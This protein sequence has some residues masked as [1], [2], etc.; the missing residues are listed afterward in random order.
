MAHIRRISDFGTVF[1]EPENYDNLLANFFDS[2]KINVLDDFYKREESK[3]KNTID[4]LNFRIYLETQR[5]LEN[6]KDINICKDQILI[7]LFKEISIFIEEIER[8]NKILKEKQ[9]NQAAIKDRVDFQNKLRE[10]K[11]DFKLLECKY[12]TLSDSHIKMVAENEDLKNQNEFYCEQLKS[13]IESKSEKISQNDWNTKD[14]IKKSF[15]ANHNGYEINLLTGAT[16]DTNENI[17]EIENPSLTNIKNRNSKYSDDNRN[18]NICINSN[19]HSENIFNK[20]CVEVNNINI[21]LNLH[22]KNNNKTNICLNNQS[23]H[24]DNKKKEVGKSSVGVGQ[25]KPTYKT[26]VKSQFS[27]FLNN[28]KN[29]DPVIKHE[30]KGQYKNV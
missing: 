6:K 27:T 22:L 12:N 14:S 8:L 25:T 19:D 4:F 20:E 23:I 11:K 10:L 16:K 2:I 15:I 1:C 3:F 17:I 9:E 28:I 29:N 26:G 5:C 24:K 7:I 30:I 21:N 13:E 18:N